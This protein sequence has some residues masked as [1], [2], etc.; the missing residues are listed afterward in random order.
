MEKKR[1]VV[2]ERLRNG[3]ED[4]LLSDNALLLTTLPVLF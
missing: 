3:R 4:K 2:T 1:K